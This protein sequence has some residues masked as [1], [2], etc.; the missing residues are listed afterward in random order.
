MFPCNITV[1]RGFGLVLGYL[2]NE[3]EAV[4]GFAVETIGYC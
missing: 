1:S 3:V 2:E 4:P